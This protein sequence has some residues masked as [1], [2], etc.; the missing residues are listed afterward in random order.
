VNL[1]HL[2][3]SIAS[4]ALRDALYCEKVYKERDRILD[5]ILDAESGKEVTNSTVNGESFGAML[6]LDRGDRLE[7]FERAIQYIEAGIVPSR[8]TKVIFTAYY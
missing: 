1:Y 7:V 3:A 5:E 2:S 4:R 6:T 8:K